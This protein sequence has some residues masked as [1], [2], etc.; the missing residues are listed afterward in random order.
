MSDIIKCCPFCGSKCVEVARTNKDA[1]WICCADCG[2]E[3]NSHKTR[4]GAI[5]IWNERHE[6]NGSPSL[7]V[8]DMDKDYP[9]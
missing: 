8:D 1:C 6:D 3:S 5:K 9:N 4:E 7:I 2:S